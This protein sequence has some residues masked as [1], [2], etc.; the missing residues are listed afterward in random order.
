MLF[1]MN[2]ACITTGLDGTGG[3]GG[4]T[5]DAV[6]ELVN[7]DLLPEEELNGSNASSNNDMFLG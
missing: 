1:A 7:D 5:V 6:E 4:G 2:V 3:S